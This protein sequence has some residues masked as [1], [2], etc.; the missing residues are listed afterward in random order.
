MVRCW[1]ARHRRRLLY[2]A[3]TW[4]HAERLAALTARTR[5]RIEIHPAGKLAAGITAED[6]A[7]GPLLLAVQYP[8]GRW[9]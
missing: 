9:V 4:R 5:D 3:A 7:G 6:V 1:P 8:D 2:L